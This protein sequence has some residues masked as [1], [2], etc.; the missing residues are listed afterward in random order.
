MLH[1]AWLA[2]HTPVVSC[3]APPCSLGVPRGHGTT[4]SPN[5]RI[6]ALSCCAHGHRASMGKD[7]QPRPYVAPHKRP[8]C[9]CGDR[10]GDG[11]REHGT[12][13]CAPHGPKVAATCHSVPCA[14]A[15]AYLFAFSSS[16]TPSFV[17]ARHERK[18]SVIWVLLQP[19]SY[20]ILA[21]CRT[22]IGFLGWIR[23]STPGRAP[24]LLSYAPGRS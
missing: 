10:E 17:S 7:M 24:F 15:G 23:E 6:P 12:T 21:P 14:A 20:D 22:P 3:V 9:Q 11:Q 5:G 2:A 19:C 4:R 13:A 16:A 1:H 8:G 18:R